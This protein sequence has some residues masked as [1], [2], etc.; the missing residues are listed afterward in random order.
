[1]SLFR[2]EAMTALLRWREVALAVLVA[3]WGAWLV[4]LGGYV[5][6]PFGA[7]VAAL[8]LGLGV[9]AWRR[10]RF[11]QGVGAPGV[12]EVD[13]GQIS[14]YGP[15]FGGFVA[16]PELAELRLMA[17]QGQRYWRLKQ[18]DGQMLMIPVEATG[19]E[20]LFDAFAAL[21]GMDSQALV[22][23]ISPV[24]GK[25]AG[26]RGL[27]LVDDTAMIGPV[28]WRRPARMALR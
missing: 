18:A 9:L 6:V 12:V 19:A 2:P 7:V 5:L 14:Y 20:R 1:M 3:A 4:G 13:E 11:G 16:L 26:A 22:A 28:I 10:L 27:A 24:V 21:P 8:G 17:M 25:T 15:S 23:A